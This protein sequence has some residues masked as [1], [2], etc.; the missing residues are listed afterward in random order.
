MK[1]ALSALPVLL[2]LIGCGGSVDS[3]S[4]GAIV[5]PDHA[6]LS[7]GGTVM[8]VGSLSKFGDHTV[9]GWWIKESRDQGSKF[10]CSKLDTAPKDFTGCPFGFVMYHDTTTIPSTATYYAPQTPGTY[11]VVVSFGWLSSGWEERQ[12]TASIVVVPTE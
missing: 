7:P 3:S 1:R 2:L 4:A 5:T 6:T 11:H 9:L 8:L 12:A 10:I